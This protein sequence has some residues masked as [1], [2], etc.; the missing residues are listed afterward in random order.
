MGRSGGST[1][2]A[3]RPAA[4]SPIS[5]SSP[6]R[7]LASA[8]L[9]PARPGQVLA[10]QVG[11]VQALVALAPEA[12]QQTAQKFD[13]AQVRRGRFAMDGFPE[14]SGLLGDAA[15]ALLGD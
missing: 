6:K 5:R 7:P 14:A 8:P 4:T 15:V 1:C 3:T 11:R 10:P 9:P 2:W 13:P 12:F